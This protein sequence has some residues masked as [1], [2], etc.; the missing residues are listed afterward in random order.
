MYK[1]GGGGKVHGLFWVLLQYYLLL[2]NF[3]TNELKYINA[4][5][6]AKEKNIAS[7]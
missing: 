1:D 4:D 5:F 7:F 6:N 3:L 2:C